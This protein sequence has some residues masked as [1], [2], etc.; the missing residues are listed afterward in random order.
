[1]SSGRPLQTFARALPGWKG[2][3]VPAGRKRPHGAAPCG[4]D[5]GAS[6]APCAAARQGFRPSWAARP[7]RK[8]VHPDGAVQQVHPC[9]SNRRRPSR[10]TPRRCPAR[11]HTMCFHITASFTSICMKRSC[12]YASIYIMTELR[13]SRQS[14]QWIKISVSFGQKDDAPLKARRQSFTVLRPYHS[15]HNSSW[16]GIRT[17]FSIAVV[18]RNVKLSTRKFLP[19]VLTRRRRAPRRA[20]E[21]PG[22]LGG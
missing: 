21:K 11:C 14:A 1:M 8:C 6:R 10:Q 22:R 19:V 3:C 4:A 5:G 16:Y 13:C 12:F 9:R 2:R 17:G 7:C 15:N 18:C 20:L